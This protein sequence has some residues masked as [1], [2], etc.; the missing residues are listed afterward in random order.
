MLQVL[1]PKV[2]EERHNQKSIRWATNSFLNTKNPD[3]ESFKYTNKFDVR[4]QIIQERKLKQIKVLSP[5]EKK[6]RKY[7]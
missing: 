7:S 3:I 5:I 2:Y 6:Y 1:A 4:S